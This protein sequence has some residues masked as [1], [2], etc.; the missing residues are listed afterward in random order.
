M[1]TQTAEH[2][3]LS[4]L[5]RSSLETQSAA[6]ETGDR[7]KSTFQEDE[8]VPAPFCAWL[9]DYFRS[10]QFIATCGQAADAK[11]SQ[12][13]VFVLALEEQAEHLTRVPVFEH[14]SDLSAR[15]GRQTG[16]AFDTDLDDRKI[17]G[18]EHGRGRGGHQD[19][20]FVLLGCTEDSR[21]ASAHGD[22]N[23]KKRWRV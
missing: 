19:L 16:E 13:H 23:G 18:C 10:G 6:S 7:Q 2:L 22:T 9:Q 4:S 17:R 20:G 3:T 8:S 5:G 11:K 21:D 1:F 15:W 14:Q 12:V